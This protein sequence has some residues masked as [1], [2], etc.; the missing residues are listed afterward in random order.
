M[1][2]VNVAGPAANNLDFHKA[3]VI[4]YI[5]LVWRILM[6]RRCYYGFLDEGTAWVY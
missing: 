6:E 3:K 5:G 1:L 2:P 4:L